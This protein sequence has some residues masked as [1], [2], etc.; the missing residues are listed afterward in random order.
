METALRYRVELEYYKSEYKD[1]HGSYKFNNIGDLCGEFSKLV[2][3]GSYVEALKI[4][5]I[6]RLLGNNVKNRPTNVTISEFY[7]TSIEKYLQDDNSPERE[8]I[9]LAIGISCLQLF[10]QNNYTGPLVGPKAAVL[11]P[12]LISEGKSEDDVRIEAIEELVGDTEGLYSLLNGPEFLLIARLIF[13]DLRTLLKSCLSVEWW[14]FRCAVLHQRVADEKSQEL[15]EILLQSLNQVENNPELLNISKSRDI[16]ALFHLEAAHLHLFYY[17]VGRAADH[18]E[19]AKNALSVKIY[20]T[21]A[22]G[23]RTKWQQEDRAQLVVKVEYEGQPI[24]QQEMP[25]STLLP[26]DLPK[27]VLLDDDTRLNK[28]KFKEQDEDVIPDMRSIEQCLILGDIT[29]K[30]RSQPSDIQ[31]DQ[32]TKAYNAA[33]LQFPNNWAMQMSGLLMRCR[34]EASE[35]RAMQRSLEQFEELVAAVNREEPSRFER[36]KLFYSSIV[37]S[38]WE[39]QQEL[40]KMLMRLGCVKS[41]LEI[42]ERL[43]LWEDVIVCYNDLQMRQRSAEVIRNE[44]EKGETPKLWCL[45]G[46]AT[47]DIECY[48]KAWEMSNH[49]SGRAQR[50]LGNYYYV[51]KEYTKAIEHYE[52]SLKRNAL[53]FPV[54]QR[55]AYCAMQ[56]EEWEKCAQ[57]YRRCSVLE[58]DSFEVWNNMS[59]A[60]IK[61]DQKP[62]AWKS[63][64]E[65]LRCNNNSWKLWDNF[66]L[67]STSLGYTSHAVNA[68]NQIL[69]KKEKHVDTQILGRIVKAIQGDEKD[70]EG[71]QARDL[72]KRCSELMGRLSSQVPS[73]PE[74]WFLYGQLTDVNPEPTTETRHLAMQHYKKAL[75]TATQ[76]SNWDKD[77]GAVLCIINYALLLML[78]ALESAKESAPK[79]AI[80][81][82]GGVR[83]SVHSTITGVKRGQ[84]NIA[85]G[86]IVDQVKEPLQKLEASLAD[87]MA[88]IDQ[89]KKESY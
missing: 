8:H 10:A 44:M 68:Y 43:H 75:A 37:L 40:A 88:Q 81:T 49:K 87:I 2:L 50:C 46:D 17:D 83:L 30:R 12:G 7:K 62:R 82:L 69:S 14:C 80:A 66:M 57:A 63:L 70:P 19:K 34:V 53:Q 55:Q 56:T 3:I 22:L 15:Y 29:Q 47:D 13:V 72:F 20:L 24:M 32:E 4:D 65:A 11:L 89:L 21:G 51:R 18:F 59:Q 41:A 58:P 9:I 71:R 76:K 16:T 42:F 85:T 35:N 86:E 79:A 27:D 78:A 36:L 28:F 84:V 6:Q 1:R 45:L 5:E 52:I 26:G 38:H 23:K 73:H 48:N 77:T 25:G 60:Y 61:L 33:L 54:W 31:L 74:I 64:Q 39:L 67:V